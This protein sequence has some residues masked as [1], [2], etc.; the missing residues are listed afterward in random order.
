L[1]QRKANDPL[2]H[3]IGMDG[4]LAAYEGEITLP[5]QLCLGAERSFL[6]GNAINTIFQAPCLAPTFAM[7]HQNN[8]AVFPIAREGLKYQV[9]DA[10]YQSYGYMCDEIV[11][12]AHH[13]FDSSVPVYS[14]TVELTFSRQG[15]EPSQKDSIVAFFAD[16]IAGLV[17]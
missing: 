1:R 10:I 3:I 2:M 15:L 6:T 4:E 7:Y 11:L 8:M 9:Q 14:R 5:G 13:V 16:S 12:D 17:L